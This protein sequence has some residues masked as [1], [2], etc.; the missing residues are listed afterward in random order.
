MLL[1]VGCGIWFVVML[2]MLLQDSS[3]LEERYMITLLPVSLLAFVI[4]TFLVLE[5]INVRRAQRELPGE[6]GFIDG[7]RI[8]AETEAQMKKDLADARSKISKVSLLAGAACLGAIAVFFGKNNLYTGVAAFILIVCV[9]TFIAANVEW[10]A[11][12]INLVL[13]EDDNKSVKAASRGAAVALPHTGD[14]LEAQKN[15]PVRYST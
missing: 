8:D 5:E 11:F 7:K 12:Y 9:I 2:L 6:A 4:F 15:M 13:N 14:D 10:V 1:S 3:R